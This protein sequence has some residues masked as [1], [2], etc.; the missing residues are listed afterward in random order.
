MEGWNSFKFEII[1]MSDS[2]QSNSAVKHSRAGDEFHYRWAARRCLKL[3][4]PSAPLSSIKIE[5]SKH[6]KLAGEYVIDVSEYYEGSE[7]Q[8]GEIVYYQLKHSSVRVE[9]NFTLS[10]LK[11]TITDFAARFKDHKKEKA[12]E[13]L[14]FKIVTNRKVS[15][16]LKNAIRNIAT[17]QAVVN[18]P[19]EGLKELTK[20]GL[21]R[22]KEFCQCVSIIDDEGDYKT[23][24]VQLQGE[25]ADFIAGFVDC[26][27]V[28]RIVGL[29]RSRVLPDSDR[30]ITKEDVFAKLG[31]TS[32]REL[33]PAPPKFERVEDPIWRDEFDG[34]LEKI[35]ATDKPIIVTAEGGV[36]KTVF[37]QEL[38]KSL[39][40]DSRGIVYDCFGAGMYR[41]QSQ[42]RHEARQALLQIANE[43]AQD[44]LCRHMIPRDSTP[45][46][47]FLRS[48][49]ER[50]EQA[51]KSLRDINSSAF[52]LIV[53]DAADN[54]ELAA[55]DFG[56]THCFANELLREVL[57]E[58]CKLV[59]TCRPEREQLLRAPSYVEILT[60]KS[61]NEEE[62]LIHMRSKYPHATET[63]AVEFH[64]LSGGNPRVQASVLYDPSSDSISATL[65]LLGPRLTTVDDQI[66]NQLNAAIN[67]LKDIHGS[68]ISVEIDS[69]C[70]GLANLPPLIPID[71]LARAAGASVGAVKSFIS[72]LGRPL[73]F[74]DE[75]VLFRDE[76]TET[77]FHNSFAASE[78]QVANYIERLKPL[79]NDVAYV[80]RALPELLLK[81]NMYEELIGQAINDENLPENDSVDTKS[82]RIYRL[83]FALKAA[84]GK[85]DYKA[86]SQ[87]AL[88]LGEELAGDD[89]QHK[90]M[91]A[92]VD[93]IAPFLEPYRA[94]ELAFQSKFSS[95]WLGS[96]NLFSASLLSIVGDSEGD[97]RGFLR[98]AEK[99]L[100]HYFECREE[101]KEG[102]ERD[103]FEQRLTN[104]DISEFHWVNFNLDGPEEF[105]DTLSG[106]TPKHV[107]FEA[108]KLLARRLIDAGR[109]EELER[110]VSAATHHT[111]I[112]LAISD[113]LVRV[114]RMIDVNQLGYTVEML[115]S[116]TDRP[117]LQHNWLGYGD[118]GDA[119]VSVLET[120]SKDNRLK[121]Q[122]IAILDHYSIDKPKKIPYDHSQNKERNLFL[123]ALTLRAVLLDSDEPSISELREEWGMSERSR[124][125]A[126]DTTYVFEVLIPWYY[127]RIQLIAGVSGEEL[128]ELIQRAPSPRHTY[129]YRSLDNTKSDVSKMHFEVLMWSRA[130]NDSDYE[131]FIDQCI[132]PSE[133]RF[134]TNDQL[135]SLRAAA[136]LDHLSRLVLPLE[137][138]CAETLKAPSTY[139]SP[140]ERSDYYILLARALYSVS[141]ADAA[142]Y[143]LRALE[144]SEKF[145]EEVVPR[146]NSIVSIA[147][148][149]SRNPQNTHRLTYEFVRCAEFVGDHIDRE[150]HW[151]RD[152]VFEVALALH[153]PA[154]LSALSRW[155]DRDVGFFDHQYRRLILSGIDAGILNAKHA[156]CFSG[157]EAG[158]ASPELAGRCMDAL[159]RSSQQ[160]VFNQLVRDLELSGVIG[161]NVDVL[162]SLVEK[163]KLDSSHFSEVCERY[164]TASSPS[165]EGAMGRVADRDRAPKSNRWPSELSHLNLGSFDGLKGALEVY[166]SLEYP[167]DLFELLRFLSTKISRGRETEFIELLLADYYGIFDCYDSSELIETIRD[168]WGHLV[169]VKTKW[170]SY[171]HRLGHILSD[172][173]S[174]E[175]AIRFFLTKS[176]LSSSELSKLK[177]GVIDGV[178]DTN[179]AMGQRQLFGFVSLLADYISA[180]DAH[181]LLHYALS[182]FELHMSEECGDGKWSCWLEAPKNTPKAVAGFIWAS[183]GSPDSRVRWQAAHSICR[184]VSTASFEV[185]RYLVDY[186]EGEDCLAFIGKG[187]PFYDL[188][189]KLYFFIGLNRAASDFAKVLIPCS[190]FVARV[191][192]SESKHLLIQTV[193]AEIALKIEAEREGT[194][195]EAII[196]EL[197]LV[198]HS[199]FPQKGIGRDKKYS[200]ARPKY[201]DSDD[202]SGF[203]LGIDFEPSWVRP[204]ADA[205]GLSQTEL[206]NEV[207]DEMLSLYGDSVDDGFISDP[208]QEYWNQRSGRGHRDTW[209]RHS[210]YPKVDRL[211][212]YLSYH[213]LMIVAS[214]RLES[215][216][217][218]LDE[219]YSE[220]YD[221]WED[222]KRRHE[223]VRSDGSW[224]CEHRD[225]T[226]AFRSEWIKRTSEDIHEWSLDYDIFQDVLINSGAK[227]GFITVDANWTDV[228]SSNGVEH[229]RIRTALIQRETSRALASYLRNA[230]PRDCFF[231]SKH[232]QEFTGGFEEGL[233]DELFE[234]MKI[235]TRKEG[236]SERRDE[237]DPYANQLMNSRIEL[238][239]ELIS[240]FGLKPSNFKREWR[241]PEAELVAN[242]IV[243]RDECPNYRDEGSRSGSRLS[244][245]IDFLLQCSK[246]MAADIV[247][248]V[249]IERRN[250]S[251]RSRSS[252]GDNQILESHKVFILEPNGALTDG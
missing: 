54:A 221:E 227:E 143:F 225:G 51:I 88:R 208:R 128:G 210:S 153:P 196:C 139:E 74:S 148:V 76:P 188:H 156:W 242:S 235:T 47:L 162:R 110:V 89:R 251:N 170:M 71:V 176:K 102:A 104:K 43:L 33:L 180:E 62:S 106:W 136:R 175:G 174:N 10:E 169:S 130:L 127:R 84:L 95:A 113:E 152:E 4:A 202:L 34:I 187:L 31:V 160:L 171:L 68:E 228:R 57:P 3:I 117:K 56:E 198:G 22:L 193:A 72:D 36:G 150:K 35:V 79:T 205:F 129:G 1:P 231:P 164:D 70:H 114:G 77:W 250:S 116:E 29:V 213:A 124:R 125:D 147:R 96:E 14:R 134:W 201:D 18:R 214:K 173:F 219:S 59:M 65:S 46:D 52:L 183:L 212:F 48:L 166:R 24:K 64:R 186:Y 172:Q 182:R 123:R 27:Y 13:L 55:R 145:G 217:T 109:F 115:L 179:Q 25:A 232:N 131:S 252:I 42:R 230:D 126:E 2:E 203:T 11:K 83:Q 21:R 211:D 120:C 15:P 67:R 190:D 8:P 7:Q 165:D 73:W 90:V 239:E 167:K 32:L 93:L 177:L 142:V 222:W 58:G 243:W 141:A 195:I 248:I 103:E 238:A 197:R 92:N 240:Q 16:E 49:L 159:S 38:I 155:R 132:K 157:F 138:L 121:D 184:S 189:A 69:I 233:V 178:R 215:T 185:V 53:I 44:G 194:Y 17:G 163:Y 80:A 223:F 204:L 60:L 97:A 137:Q 146:W 181:E 112:I 98:S 191:A 140:E 161:S 105:V 192:L 133:L 99:W 30:E 39:P 119:I 168:L 45:S 41:S 94:Q 75:S 158:N 50:I 87:I 20:L 207:K 246:E 237:H 19:L 82:I 28:D 122:V 224:L 226:P 40:N 107:Q 245:S 61:F 229:V 23:Q 199:P 206:V 234:P 144:S 9:Q 66:A 85:L 78:E 149:A 220:P 108:A 6:N 91:S 154:A 218:I 63:Q 249:E 118:L 81:A 135:Y 200:N 247:I 100:R 37:V 5:G 209:Y 86:A 241:T 12:T 26:D 151:D 101:M 111:Y 236:A 244:A 216:P